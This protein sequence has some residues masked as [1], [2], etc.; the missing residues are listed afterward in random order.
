MAWTYEQVNRNGQKC[1]GKAYRY[2]C[3]IWFSFVT[4]VTT[5]TENP[6]WWKYCHIQTFWAYARLRGAYPVFLTQKFGIFSSLSSLRKTKL[7]PAKGQNRQ[8]PKTSRVACLM[9]ESG[10][11]KIV[12]VS[13]EEPLQK[14][15]DNWSAHGLFHTAWLRLSWMRLSSHKWKGFVPRLDV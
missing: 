15:L 13:V 2:I 8:N 7:W 3:S 4:D 11:V 1:A 12:T 10:A 9:W 14:K 6:K 5:T